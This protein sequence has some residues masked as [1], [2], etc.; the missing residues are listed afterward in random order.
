M[1]KRRL[2]SF[3]QKGALVLLV[4][5]IL[6]IGYVVSRWYFRVEQVEIVADEAIITNLR[7]LEAVHNTLFVN[8]DR[9]SQK[10][11]NDN[12][13]AK[14]ITI[15]RNFP[16]QLIIHAQKRIPVITIKDHDSYLFLDEEGFILFQKESNDDLPILIVPSIDVSSHGS[17]VDARIRNG[18]QLVLNSIHA[19]FP[20]SK[21][22]VTY[23]NNEIV[24]ETNESHIIA[25]LNQNPAF[26]FSS[27]QLL[28]RQF[29][30]EGKR[31]SFI[32]FRF[33]KPI[34]RFIQT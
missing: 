31:P 30:I 25:L 9:L 24:M 28:A 5:A 27:L 2:I 22:E 10:I 1:I 4:L 18:I 32:D 19:G 12:P 13:L 29:R 17:I 21:S 8:T 16:N 23:E 20:V 34:V 14:Q 26:L 15:Q 11:Q 6:G 3:V 33:E 7:S